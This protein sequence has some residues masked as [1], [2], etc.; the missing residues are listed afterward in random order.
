[1]TGVGAGGAR[2]SYLSRL[3]AQLDQIEQDYAEV[4]RRSTI[5]NI[6]PNR[7]HGGSGVAFIG[8]A[9]YGWGPSDAALEAA[10]MDLLKRVRD[11]GP[12]YRLLFPHP[13]KTVS[14]RLDASLDLLESW[15]VRERRD[16]AHRLP[17][18]TKEAVT[19]LAARVEDL[20]GLSTLLPADE[21]AVRVAPDTNTLIDN[22]DLAAHT[23]SLGPRYMGTRAPRRLWRARRPQAIGPHDGPPRGGEEG[24]PTAQRTSRQW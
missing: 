16:R 9:K 17:P 23:A 3:L 8:F 15:L 11:W 6:D 12:R 4:L 19:L 1:V 24:G 18:S 21:Y 14:A 10:R 13:V 5:L 22:P 20:R 7:R 2:P